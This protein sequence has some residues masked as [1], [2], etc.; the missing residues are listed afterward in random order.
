MIDF[1]SACL[2]TRLAIRSF[3]R[4][5]AASSLADCSS[6]LYGDGELVIVFNCSAEA[7]GDE[8]IGDEA[9]GDGAIG[10]EL[11]AIL[12]SFFRVKKD[13]IIDEILNPPSSD[14]LVRLLMRDF[15]A[16]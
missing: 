2:S 4:F 14:F 1:L 8:A 11:G 10:D 16:L 9:I 3:I 7:N 5:A 13:G 6:S 12:T 15:L